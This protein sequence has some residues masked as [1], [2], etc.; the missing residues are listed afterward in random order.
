MISYEVWRGWFA[1]AEPVGHRLRDVL[2]GRWVRFHNL[3]DDKRY[4]EN[5]ADFATLLDRHNSV[6]VEL[7]TPGQPV[8]L[9]TTE[10][11]RS[12]IPAGRDAIWQT[13]DP[14]AVAWRTVEIHRVD[15]D[16][17]EGYWHVYA[18]EHVWE[19]GRLDPIIRLVARDVVQ[20]HHVLLLDPG[21]RWAIWP[22]DGGMDIIMESW[23]ARDRLRARHPDWLP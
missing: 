20:R 1:G 14:D 12:A 8:M 4:P 23:I 10:G 9:L 17:A 2:R 5:E 19:R 16:F 7:T 6:L 15:P 3:P 21:C 11:S 22:Y 13:L 18:S